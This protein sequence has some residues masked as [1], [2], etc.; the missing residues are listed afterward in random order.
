MLDSV[1]DS[2]EAAVKYSDQT[3]V[4]ALTVR[5]GRQTNHIHTHMMTNCYKYMKEREGA[6]TVQQGPVLHWAGDAGLCG[7][8][9]LS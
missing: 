6:E 7:K 8:L 4:L 5:C 1:L 3:S 9:C 2:K